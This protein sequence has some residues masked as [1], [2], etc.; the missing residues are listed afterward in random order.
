MSVRVRPAGCNERADAFEA[1]CDNATVTVPGLMVPLS[2]VFDHVLPASASQRDLF[3]SVAAPIARGT[4]DGFN[5]T[6]LTYGQTGSGKSFTCFGEGDGEARGLVPR[7]L[8][9]VFAHL[10]A[11]ASV[12]NCNVLL[13]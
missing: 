1:D 7:T 10:A 12:I 3:D 4:L 8:E 6:I 2:Y 9:F 11:K 13:S 5:G